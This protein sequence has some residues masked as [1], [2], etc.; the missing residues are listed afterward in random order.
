MEANNYHA[1]EPPP[2]AGDAAYA[3]TDR[4]ADASDPAA[5]ASADLTPT[6][7]SVAADLLALDAIAGPHRQEG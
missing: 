4:A 3:S 6:A 7:R 1:V 2:K 5:V